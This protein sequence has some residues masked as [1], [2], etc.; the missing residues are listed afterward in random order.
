MKTLR[1]EQKLT[2]ALWRLSSREPAPW[3]APL[4][5][6]GGVSGCTS[7]A[8]RGWW[9][10]MVGHVRS[11]GQP[12]SLAARQSATRPLRRA[13]PFVFADSR[14]DFGA[15]RLIDARRVLS[16]G[17]FAHTRS[18]ANT[19][20]LTDRRFRP[21]T[22][23]SADP[24]S[25]VGT[26]RLIDTLWPPDMG[27]LANANAG[28]RGSVLSHLAD[29]RLLP[30]MGLSAH[31]RWNMSTSRLTDMRPPTDM[32]L[33]ANAGVRGSVLSLLADTRAHGHARLPSH[34]V[35]DCSHAKRA[36][37]HGRSPARE[38]CMPTGCYSAR[39]V[40]IQPS[41]SARRA[42]IQGDFRTPRTPRSG[43]RGVCIQT[44]LPAR[45]A[46]IQPSLPAREACI[47]PSVP[48]REACIQGVFF[49]AREACI[50]TGCYSARE[51][52]IQ[53]SLPARR[54]C[55]QSAFS[56][57]REACIHGGFSSSIP[58]YTRQPTH[59]RSPPTTFTER[60]DYPA[61]PSCLTWREPAS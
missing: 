24:R 43:P 16:M 15:P 34:G 26:A 59:I 47:Q 5:G 53:P 8:S 21:D 41:L 22:C 33:F 4:Y 51:A 18:D 13:D 36:S 31:P 27:L 30:D 58:R 10:G 20:R 35:P 9:S 49:S 11:S 25:D 56:S 17:L 29:S 52:C 46:C 54:A 32:A 12:V 45:E 7:G 40:C 60:P 1:P 37:T 28:L 39:E 55:I 50:P 44:S 38:A 42:C 48:A 57:A 3:C 61:T 2:R 19:L 6:V 23:L 14:S